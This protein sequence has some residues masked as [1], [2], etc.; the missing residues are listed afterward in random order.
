VF[1]F[2][3]IGVGEAQAL[4]LALG[5]FALLVFVS[6]LGALGFLFERTDKEPGPA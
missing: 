3:R 1:F 6:L 5:W 4:A 2:A